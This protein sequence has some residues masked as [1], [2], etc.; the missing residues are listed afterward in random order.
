MTADAPVILWFRDDLRLTDHAALHAAIETGRPVLPLFILDDKSP[1]AWTMG[2][3]SRWWLHHSLAALHQ[4]MAGL[5][6]GL[7]L[8]RGN[9]AAIIGELT[10]QTGATEIFTGGSADPWAR[11]LDQTVAQ[12][13][14]GKLHRMRTT[15][16]FNPDAVRSKTGAPYQVYT[17][18]AEACL[19]LGGPKPP[20]PAP[21]K[22][23][24][25]AKASPTD[26][27]QDWDLLPTKPDWASGLRETWTPGEAGAMLRADA[28]LTHGLAGYAAARNQPAADGTS[29]LSPHL[30]FGEIS[31]AQLWH[32]AYQGP[33]R[34][35]RKAFIRE[36]LWREFCANLLWHN[37]C[38][39][40]TPLQPAFEKMPWRD[41]KPALTA[42][43]RGQTGV[44]IVDAGMRQLWQTGWMHNRVRMIVASFL[45]KHLLLPWQDGEAWFW[46]TLV[47][48]DLANNA[49]NWQWVAGCGVDA[50]P[51]FRIF[52]P[53]LQ[54]RKFDPSGDYIRKFVPELRCL[55][56]RHIH[57]PWEAPSDVLS[58]A[59][60]NLGTTYP[61]PIVDL[62]TGRSRALE[63][64]AH[65]RRNT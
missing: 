22:R 8:R 40:E 46:D 19:A 58:S 35:S 24:H 56:A 39:P 21:P 13:L 26:R 37:P 2:G 4:S 38:L 32:K 34:E 51:Y 44:P 20:L 1:G 60:I 53:V 61:N 5:N 14:G 65:V 59:G 62:A 33:G 42:W 10:E 18:F 55:G 7:T 3:A 23:I 12:S 15:T 11:R 48:A 9:S 50:A 27:L 64:Y 54:S 41:D 17:A 16:L 47:D 6:T 36:L 57:A 29:M 45:T 30:H 52:N 31:P 28:F 43:Q 63:A 49:G 25:A